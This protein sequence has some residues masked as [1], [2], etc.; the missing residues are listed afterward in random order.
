MVG[1]T[2]IRLAL[3]GGDIAHSLSPRLFDAAL[4]A[5][6]MAGRYELVPTT[7]PQLGSVLQQLMHSHHGINITAPFKH[8]AWLW[9]EQ[10]NP[11]CSDDVAAQTQACNVLVFGGGTVVAARNT[12]VAGLR[13]AWHHHGWSVHGEHVVVVGSGGAAAAACLAAHQ[14]GVA[15]VTVVTRPAVEDEQL[16]RRQNLQRL[17]QQVSLLL[18]WHG[19]TGP[20]ARS[21]GVVQAAT[22]AP[23]DMIDRC[24]VRSGGFVHDLRTPPRATWLSAGNA[25]WSCAD[26]RTMLVGQALA[27]FEGFAGVPASPAV[28]SAMMAA[29]T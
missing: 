28:V 24:S 27:A 22:T 6:A 17:A 25:Q 21:A 15:L 11:G 12:D 23:V 3:V 8:A 19:D 18:H 13:F 2:M 9:A 10:Q 16:Q 20:T 29:S 5:A 7:A 4:A 14:E 1:T 26:G